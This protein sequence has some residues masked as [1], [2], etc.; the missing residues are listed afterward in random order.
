MKIF[1][2]AILGLIVLLIVSCVVILTS[3]FLFPLL[4]YIEYLKY[5]TGKKT[6]SKNL[7]QSVNDWAKTLEK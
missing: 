5:K 4:G 7:I 6:K 3:P 2:L 1:G